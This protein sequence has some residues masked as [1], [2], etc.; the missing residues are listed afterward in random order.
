[1]TGNGTTLNSASTSF[2][3]FTL[4]NN[5]IIS[6]TISTYSFS[7][8]SGKTLTLN[9]AINIRIYSFHTF[10]N[11]G[12][13]S[14]TGSL[15][16][17]MYNGN[18]TL[19]LGQINVPVTLTLVGGAPANYM[20]TLSATTTLGSTFTLIANQHLI[21]KSSTLTIMLFPQLTSR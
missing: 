8:A 13:I 18:Q 7:L 10:T 21:P 14:G 20:A 3:I 2:N 1:M 19:A 11:L 16:L 12:S 5:V 17:S 6:S 9:S 15:T 4:S